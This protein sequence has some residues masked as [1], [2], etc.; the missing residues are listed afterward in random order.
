MS[1]L[2]DNPLLKEERD[3]ARNPV[4]NVNQTKDW[5]SKKQTYAKNYISSKKYRIF[6]GREEREREK[7]RKYE[8]ASE[9]VIQSIS[10]A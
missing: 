3:P 4:D 1:G 7:E 6:P 8:D 10:M 2:L 9:P 5:E